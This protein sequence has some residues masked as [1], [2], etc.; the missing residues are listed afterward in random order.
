MGFSYR[1]YEALGIVVCELIGA[2][3]TYLTPPGNEGGIDFFALMALPS[4]FHLFRQSRGPLRIVGQSK[5]HKSPVAVGDVRDFITALDNVRKRQPTVE[6]HVPTWFRA[7]HGPILGLL[8]GHRGFQS[9]AENMARDHGIV[10]ADSLDLAEVATLARSISEYLK[11][12]ERAE[13]LREMVKNT[14][15]TDDPS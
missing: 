9:G 6:P 2:S 15:I 3:K 13:L 10:T 7:A 11:L 12:N 1:Q 8:C 4:K 5:Q 14:L